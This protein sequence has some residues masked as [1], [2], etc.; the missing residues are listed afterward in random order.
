MYLPRDIVFPKMYITF[1]HYRSAHG[2]KKCAFENPRRNE[3]AARKKI[4]S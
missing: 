4:A 2:N 3:P 1:R